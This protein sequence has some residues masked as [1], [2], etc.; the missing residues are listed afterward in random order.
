MTGKGP[1]GRF[2]TMNSKPKLPKYDFVAGCKTEYFGPTDRT[3]ARVIAT[4]LN[5]KRRIIRPW[6]YEL[7]SQENHTLVASEL[8]DTK[9][10]T[11]CSVQGGGYMFLKG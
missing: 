11:G 5:T 4:H 6:R 10:L 3:G 9:K 7:D 1:Q 2:P 8:L